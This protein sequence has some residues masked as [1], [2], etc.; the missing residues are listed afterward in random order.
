LNL[1][2]LGAAYYTGN[3]HKWLC[4][5]KGAAFLHV[6]RDRQEL[7]RPLVISHGANSPR[8]DRSRFLI[9]FGWMGT[10]DPTACLSVPEAL[11]VVGSL[12]PGGWLEVMQRNRALA[13]AGRKI[14]CQTLRIPPPCPGELIGSLAALPIPDAFDDKPTNNPLYL[15]PLQE[16]LLSRHGIEVPVIPWP[17]HPKRVL[18]ISAQLYNSLPQ[19]ERLAEALAKT[20]P[21]KRK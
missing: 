17:A 18:R 19:Y 5:P 16:K 1:N 13:L 15:D 2:Q 3:C 12:L 14:L 11:R 6:R 8:T 10:G 20:L 4:A 21:L 9:E 7:I